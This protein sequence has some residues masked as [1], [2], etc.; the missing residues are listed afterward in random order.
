MPQECRVRSMGR[1]MDFRGA[2]QFERTQTSWARSNVLELSVQLMQCD[3]PR[4]Y[5]YMYNHV[6][7]YMCMYRYMYMRKMHIGKYGKKSCVHQVYMFL[8]TEIRL[9]KYLEYR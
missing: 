2:N 6:H 7:V 9:R 8:Y 1:S 4:M 3:I 5:M